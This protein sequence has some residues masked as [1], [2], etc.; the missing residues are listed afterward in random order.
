MYYFVGVRPSLEYD[1]ISSVAKKKDECDLFSRM[2]IY[3]H[4]FAMSLYNVFQSFKAQLSHTPNLLKVKFEGKEYEI[5]RDVL[6]QA[7]DKIKA[8][9]EMCSTS[10]TDPSNHGI[11]SSEDLRSCELSY[12]SIFAIALDRLCFKVDNS[13]GCILH[14]GP[15][16]K[17]RRTQEN[18]D[19]AD[20]LGVRESETNVLESYFV[21]DLKKVDISLSVKESA[22]YGKFTSLASQVT[23]NQAVLVM[24]L[25]A[26]TNSASLW[27]Y[28]MACRRE[29]VI[30]II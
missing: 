20:I 3:T 25:A 8:A 4:W 19:T 29:W 15:V 28:L 21:S 1:S 6:E 27:V 5:K 2:P 17:K 11:Q 24:G 14:Q 16:R 13:N 30:P 12:S 9:A 22:L 26:T 18:P 10:T 23:S 7:S